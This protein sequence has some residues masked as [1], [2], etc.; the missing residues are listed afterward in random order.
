MPVITY[1]AVDRG[2]LKS[3][4]SAGT[5]YQIEC[6]LQAFPRSSEATG[7][8]DQTLDGTP[9]AYVD[10]YLTEWA[11]TSDLIFPSAID[12]WREFLSSVAG[13][14]KF[15]LDFT[16]TIA[17]PGTD[18]DVWLKTKRVSEQQLGAAGYQVS[19]AVQVYP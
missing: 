7:Q 19:F 8:F 10:A 5:Q 4:H 13:R 9:E 14:E 17:L 3:G 18:I 6:D 2:Q 15:Q 1:T 11:I 16:G 12:D